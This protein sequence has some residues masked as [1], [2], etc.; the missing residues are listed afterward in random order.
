MPLIPRFTPAPLR[1]YTVQYALP[2]RQF[3][4]IIRCLYPRF[5]KSEILPLP[6][7]QPFRY[8]LRLILFRHRPA[9][10]DPWLLNVTNGTVNLRT[11]EF[12]EHRLEDL[13]TKFASV[14]YDE[15]ADCPV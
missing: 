9:D 12:R 5:Y 13:I 10:R 1:H 11:G 2:Y 14:D 6:F 15:K 3:S 4:R 8:Q 7:P